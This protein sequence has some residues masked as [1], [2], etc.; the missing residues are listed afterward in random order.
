MMQSQNFTFTFTVDQASA[1]Q[2]TERDV[3]AVGGDGVVHTPTEQ[4]WPTNSKSSRALNWSV[5]SP[6]CSP[7]RRH[8]PGFDGSPLRTSVRLFLSAVSPK[9]SVGHCRQVPRELAPR[10]ERSPL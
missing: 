8:R 2:K 3:I 9:S 6:S 4:I 10:N 1:D 5:R 7:L